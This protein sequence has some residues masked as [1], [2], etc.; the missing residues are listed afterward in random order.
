MNKERLPKKSLK[1]TPY[2]KKGR[3][4]PRRIW[5]E[6]IGEMLTTRGVQDGD[7]GGG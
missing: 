3:G 6:G 5:L 2:V 1:W 7:W 4:K